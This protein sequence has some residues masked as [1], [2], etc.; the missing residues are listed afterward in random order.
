[1]LMN[2][3]A[4]RWAYSIT[5]A[6]MLSAASSQ[7]ILRTASFYPRYAALAL[8]AVITFQGHRQ[9]KVTVKLMAYPARLLTH[10]MFLAAAIAALST[11]WSVDLLMTAQQTIALTSLAVTLYALVSRRWADRDAVTGDLAVA[12]WTLA[13]FF[14]L[15]LAGGSVGLTG[16][17]SAAGFDGFELIDFR[18]QGLAANPNML[19]ILCTPVI[20][21]GWYL[22]RR[23]HSVWYLAGT[24]PAVVSLLMSQSR[25]GVLAVSS[26]GLLILLRRGHR[27]FLR[28]TIVAGIS[29]SL[30]YLSGI[31]QKIGSSNLVSEFTARFES[32]AGGGALN[33]RA[34]AWAETI[35]L[36]WERPATGYGYA[37]GPSLFQQLRASGDL[38]FGRDVVHNSYLQWILETGVLGLPALA[39]VTF[40]CVVGA[41]S[42]SKSPETAG[43]AWGLIAGLLM[44]GT[45]SA[46]LGTGQAYPIVFWVMV[47]AAGTLASRSDSAASKYAR[48]SAPAQ[49]RLLAATSWH[50]Q[51]GAIRGP[52]ESCNG[53]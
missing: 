47:A 35:S 17:Q 33:G 31:A 9:G 29:V 4:W 49:S 20:P 32:S 13:A 15:G 2:M 27:T 30:G 43:L 3:I 11:A 44:Q 41:W 8:L 16:T 24:T 50:P 23:S 25:T 1:M 42:A 34:Q 5:L 12:F 14:S 45:E 26:A 53:H 40:A 36:A 7:P 6:L 38:A 18:F 21:L 19:A 37:A 39:A 51:S 28:S 10:G 46:M 52:H 48:G 22:Y